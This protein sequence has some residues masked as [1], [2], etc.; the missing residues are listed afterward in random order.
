MRDLQRIRDAAMQAGNF[1]AAV[2][3]EFR[4]GQA[5]GTI[6]VERKEVRYGAIDSMTA[7]DVMKELERLKD[8]YGTPSEIIDLVPEDIEHSINE[9]NTRYGDETGDIVVPET[10]GEPATRV[11]T[12]ED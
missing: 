9:E 10:E 3:A 5:L 12:D 6:Y 2:Q 4:R 11:E 1:G 7:E 8:V